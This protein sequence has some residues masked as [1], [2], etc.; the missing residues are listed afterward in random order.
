MYVRKQ[1]NMD[2]SG[3]YTKRHLLSSLTE[4]AFYKHNNKHKLNKDSC[5]NPMVSN[6]CKYTYSYQKNK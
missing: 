4:D 2:I 5:L 6:S 1:S 3:R